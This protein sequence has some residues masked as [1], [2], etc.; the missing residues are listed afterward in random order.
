MW[1]K[2]YSDNESLMTYEQKIHSDNSLM[3]YEQK[4]HSDNK[5]LTEVYTEGERNDM[6]TKNLVILRM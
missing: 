4:I 2:I 1:T 3:T 6:L 5:R